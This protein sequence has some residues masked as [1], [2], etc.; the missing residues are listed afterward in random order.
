MMRIN[1]RVNKK[2]KTLHVLMKLI[3]RRTMQNWNRQIM[4]SKLFHAIKITFFYWDNLFINA[5]LSQKNMRKVMTL[6]DLRLLAFHSVW[7]F[8]KTVGRVIKI[9]NVFNVLRWF[10]RQFV[11]N[12]DAVVF[13]RSQVSF[14][15][16]CCKSITLHIIAFRHWSHWNRVF[17][18]QAREKIE[19]VLP[20]KIRTAIKMMFIFIVVV[21]T[22]KL[23]RDTKNT[24]NIFQLAKRE[25]FAFLLGKRV[26]KS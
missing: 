6:D 9:C 8:I 11:Q 10:K 19:S 18:P 25:K 14:F 22:S 17:K 26:S 23:S 21:A 2:K 1:A 13:N 20:R 7:I 4:I 16:R 12:V 24:A 3:S 15:C 5:F